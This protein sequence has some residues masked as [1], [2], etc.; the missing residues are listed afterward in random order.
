MLDVARNYEIIDERIKA[1]KPNTEEFFVGAQPNWGLIASGADAKRDL[2]DEILGVVLKDEHLDRGDVQCV[3]IHAEAGSG[4]TALL[5]RIGVDLA[6]SWQRNW[7][8]SL[9]QP[10]SASTC[11]LTTPLTQRV[12]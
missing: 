3:L 10:K 4:K 7:S 11:S 8:G 5:R 9:K 1:V 2:S 12:I 6:L